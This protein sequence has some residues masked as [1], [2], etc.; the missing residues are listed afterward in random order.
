MQKPGY[1]L[2]NCITAYRIVMAPVLVII[3]FN[4]NI[5]LFKWLLAISFFTDLIDGL[6]ARMFSVNSAFGSMLD[7]IGDDLTVVAGTIGLIVFRSQFVTDNRLIL[8]ILFAL[9]VMQIILALIKYH[10]ISSFHTYF[11]KTAAILQGIF[12]I[13]VFFFPEPLY[14]LFYLAV[15]VTAVELLEEIVLTLIIPKWETNIKGLYWV[16]KRRNK[17]KAIKTK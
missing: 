4:N 8:I 14:F 2:I 5:A 12:L 15:I 7:S 3:I 13:L 6:L 11:A 10:K 9:F 1:Y 17:N 16:Y